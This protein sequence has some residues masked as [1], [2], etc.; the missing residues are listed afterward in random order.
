MI[1]LAHSNL[2]FSAADA[3][4]PQFNELNRVGGINVISLLP[5]PHKKLEVSAP[6]TAARRMIQLLQ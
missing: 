6:A 1:V 3:C 4:D 2:P 5:E